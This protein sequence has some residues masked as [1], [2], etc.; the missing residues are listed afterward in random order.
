MPLQSDLKLSN[1]FIHKLSACP[2][3]FYA[4]KE[5]PKMKFGRM[6][7][8]ENGEPRIRVTLAPNPI[9]KLKQREINTRLQVLELPKCMYGAVKFKNN[10]LNALEHI[11]SNYFFTIDLKDFFTNISKCQIFCALCD[12]GI[13]LEDARIITKMCTLN[14]CLPQ[15]APTSST[16]ANIAFAYTAGLLEKICAKRNIIFTAFVDDLTFSSKHDFTSSKSE[17]LHILLVN[18][19]FPNY[20][21]IH[22]RHRACEITGL[23]VKNRKLY[24][25]KNMLKKANSLGMQAYLNNIDK[26]SLARKVNSSPIEARLR[27]N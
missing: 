22:Y 2:E 4:R 12:H 8:D 6:Q 9:L 15:G 17:I 11:E 1:Q 26:Y 18:G 16:L 13:L 7:L 10:I 20:N 19:F 5:Q 25:E 24:L 27:D 21:K 14:Q 23:I 3:K